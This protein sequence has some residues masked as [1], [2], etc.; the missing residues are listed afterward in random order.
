MAK[1]FVTIEETFTYNLEIEADTKQQAE[2]LAFNNAKFTMDEWDDNDAH[3]TQIDR[4]WEAIGEPSERN[5]YMET[6]GDTVDV[7][8][9]DGDG[10][11]VANFA[12]VEDAVAYIKYK[13][14]R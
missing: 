14:G 5:H 4:A 9:Q 10:K 13:E 6:D 8:E 12:S 7:F 3:I 1:W 11:R 2:D